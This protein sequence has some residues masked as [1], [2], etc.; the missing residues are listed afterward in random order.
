MSRQIVGRCRVSGAAMRDP[1]ERHSSLPKPAGPRQESRSS[2]RA[3]SPVSS[4]LERD[5]ARRYS[6]S[7]GGVD[8]VQGGKPGTVRV[9]QLGGRRRQRQM[10][11]AG[12]LGGHP[13]K[14]APLL[15]P[16]PR[17][18]QVRFFAG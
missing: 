14:S 5:G 4:P 1:L 7:P 12:S 3:V 17:G 8:I 15:E 13:E 11:V 2:F 18:F 16:R 10:T 9:V 6:P